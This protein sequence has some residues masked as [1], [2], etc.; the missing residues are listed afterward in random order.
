MSSSFGS[1]RL[2]LSTV[3]ALPMAAVYDLWPD[4]TRAVDAEDLV[5]L[6]KLLLRGSCNVC[7][8]VCVNATINT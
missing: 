1:A 2:D 4:V 5:A 7:V 3:E 8:C 6:K